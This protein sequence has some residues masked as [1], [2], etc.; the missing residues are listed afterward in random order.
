M[1][2]QQG[3]GVRRVTTTIGTVLGAGLLAIGLW[4]LWHNWSFIGSAERTTGTVV[5]TLRDGGKEGTKHR[6]RIAFRD[7]AGTE[8]VGETHVAA[9]HYDYPEGT[10]IAVWYDPDAPQSVRVHEPFFFWGI[11]AILIVAGLVNI[12]VLRMIHARKI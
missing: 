11:P 7:G 3:M 1:A 10:E 5:E 9:S 6:A 4:L 8:H 2:H 12:V